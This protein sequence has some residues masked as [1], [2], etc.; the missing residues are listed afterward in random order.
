MDEAPPRRDSRPAGAGQFP[1][2]G[3]VVLVGAVVRLVKDGEAYVHVDGR[4]PHRQ[5]WVEIGSIEGRAV[6][7]PAPAFRT[8]DRV[9]LTGT[10]V[11]AG[12]SVVVMPPDHRPMPTPTARLRIE[13]GCLELVE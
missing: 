12:E 3:V 10:V 8:G 6:R 9:K 1:A 7:S 5:L 4:S 2:V 11:V 13:P